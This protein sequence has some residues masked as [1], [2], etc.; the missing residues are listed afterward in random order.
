MTQAFEQPAK[1]GHSLSSLRV[2]RW[3]AAWVHRH[4]PEFTGL[5]RGPLEGSGEPPAVHG[6]AERDSEVGRQAGEQLAVLGR[7]RRG[8]QVVVVREDPL[9]CLDGNTAI[10]EVVLHGIEV[11][12]TLP[13]TCRHST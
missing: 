13:L 12:V 7:E 1:S 9:A 2:T 11:H 3:G 8:V 10:H 5:T 6:D 4:R